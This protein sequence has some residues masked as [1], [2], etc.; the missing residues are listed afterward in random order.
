MTA[1]NSS[2]AITLVAPLCVG[3]IVDLPSRKAERAI[4]FRCFSSHAKLFSRSF[5]HSPGGVGEACSSS[6]AKATPI[7]GRSNERFGG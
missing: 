6:A 4:R 1:A 3:R 2:P 7:C 5:G